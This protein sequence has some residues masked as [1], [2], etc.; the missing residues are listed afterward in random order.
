MGETVRALRISFIDVAK[1]RTRAGMIAAMEKA[2]AQ[3]PGT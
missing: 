3:C 1:R 2:T